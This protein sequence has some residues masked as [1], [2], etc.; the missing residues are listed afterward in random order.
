MIISNMIFPCISL[1]IKVLNTFSNENKKELVICASLA[2][3]E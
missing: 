1:K 2:M 3:S